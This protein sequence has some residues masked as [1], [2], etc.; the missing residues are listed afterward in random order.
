MR[1]RHCR[2]VNIEFKRESIDVFYCADYVFS[3]SKVEEIKAEIDKLSPRERCELNALIQMWP[4]DEWDNQMR[5]DGE[6]GGKL[7]VLREE[8]ELEAREG[9]LRD[10]PKPAAE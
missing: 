1:K 4:D 2:I 7:D 6:P 8:A 9:R 10:Y 3:M 5:S